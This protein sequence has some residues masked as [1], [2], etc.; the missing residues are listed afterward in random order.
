MKTTSGYMILKDGK[1]YHLFPVQQVSELCDKS[2]QVDNVEV[3]EN[4][5]GDYWS[6]WDNETGR[7]ENAHYHKGGVN[8]CYPYGTSALEKLGKGQLMKVSIVK[9]E[10]VKEERIKQ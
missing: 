9:V 8:I 4:P 2:A 3:V 1:Y 10:T 6:F 7:F 5:N